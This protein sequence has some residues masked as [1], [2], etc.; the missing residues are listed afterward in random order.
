M[1]YSFDGCVFHPAGVVCGDKS[2]CPVCGWNPEVEK[3]R[4]ERI[5]EKRERME[6]LQKIEE[7]PRLLEPTEGRRRKK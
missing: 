2:L 1:V 5:R 3:A 4:I 7:R 6:A